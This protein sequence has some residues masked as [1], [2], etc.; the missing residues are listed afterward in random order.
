[1][2]FRSLGGFGERPHTQG[3]AFRFSRRVATLV[4]WSISQ[5]LARSRPASACRRKRRHHTSMRLSHAAPFGMKACSTL[6]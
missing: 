6:G 1:M 3:L 2:R 5:P 4:A